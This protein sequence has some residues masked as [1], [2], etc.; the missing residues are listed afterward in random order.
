MSCL[1]NRSKEG[2]RCGPDDWV[3]DCAQRALDKVCSVDRTNE[4][5]CREIETRCARFRRGSAA[6]TTDNCMRLVSAVLPS[7]QRAALTCVSEGCG[8]DYC[9]VSL[10]YGKTY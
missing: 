8:V 3:G 1:V 9:F 2:G 5:E 6:V 4:R 7:E 10:A